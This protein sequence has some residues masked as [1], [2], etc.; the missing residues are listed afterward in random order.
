MNGKKARR[1]R[2]E[3]QGVVGESPRATKRLARI[4]R[5]AANR[6]LKIRLLD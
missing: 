4:L 6:G 3:A 2:K 5:K 1:L